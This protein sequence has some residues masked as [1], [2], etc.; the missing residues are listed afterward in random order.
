MHRRRIGEDVVQRRW[1]TT[2]VTIY[3]I[4]APFDVLFRGDWEGSFRGS[5]W[6]VALTKSR[7][8]RLLRAPRSKGL[9]FRCQSRSIP[10][11]LSSESSTVM[12]AEL[13]SF[14][15]AAFLEPEGTLSDCTDGSSSRIV[16]TAGRFGGCCSYRETSKLYHWLLPGGDR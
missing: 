5:T 11:W 12:E 6:F 16:D 13:S 3:G 14:F 10:S 2:N 4:F 7:A 15:F 1:R 9:D 8:L